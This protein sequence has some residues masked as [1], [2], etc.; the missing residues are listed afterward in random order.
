MARRGSRV[1]LAEKL[2]ISEKALAGKSDAEIAQELER[3]VHTIRKWRRRFTQQGRAGL[4]S[5]MGRPVSGILGSYRSEL[6]EALLER[7]KAHP[8]WGPK[9]ILMELR[10]DPYWGTQQ[11]PGRARIAALLHQQGLVR[12]YDRH[13]DLPQPEREEA[14]KP[15]QIWQMDA[16]GSLRVKGLRGRTSVIH[17]ID[18]YSR[19]KIESCPR[20][21]CRKPGRADYFLALRKAFLQFGL[22]QRIS[23]DHDT[24]F[25]DNTLASPYPTRIH[26]WLVA[27]GIEVV[28]TRKRRPTDHAQVERSHQTMTAQALQGQTWG[29]EQQLWAGLDQ[30]RERLNQAYPLQILGGQAPLQAYPEAISSGRPYRPEWE[31]QLLS[32]KRVHQFL[33][34]GRWIR[35]SQNHHINLGGFRYAIG[36]DYGHQDFEITFDPNALVFLMQPEQEGEPLSIPPKGLTKPDLMGD[37]KWLLDL[38]AYQLAFPFS[39]TERHRTS[40]AQFLAGTTL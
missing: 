40:L 21:R 4:E 28:F 24:V 36:K 39:P 20:T 10:Q 25:I 7:R 22:P 12:K 9:T 16:Q 15:H 34:E 27:L 37:L 30:R 3:S 33:A 23:L 18:V 14:E 29:S 38:P 8:G 17:V 35:T 1:R 19:L 31:E 26:L 13:I 32:L 6:R 11:L 2:V 5:R